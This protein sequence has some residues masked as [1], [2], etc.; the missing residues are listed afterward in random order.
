MR[1]GRGLDRMRLRTFHA[2]TPTIL[3]KLW[4]SNAHLEQ[5][6]PAVQKSLEKTGPTRH[7]GPITVAWQ[8]IVS[9]F[10]IFPR[11]ARPFVPTLHVPLNPA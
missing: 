1:A 2:N 9:L 5:R 3:A 11:A 10:G 6:L 4:S 7:C 8:R